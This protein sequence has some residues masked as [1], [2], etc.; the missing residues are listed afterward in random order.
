MGRNATLHFYPRSVLAFGY[1]PYLQMCVCVNSFLCHNS[2][3]VQARILQTFTQYIGWK[4]KVSCCY[5]TVQ[6]KTIF[7]TVLYWFRHY[8]NQRHLIT[9]NRWI[10]ECLLWE[11]SR[12]LTA[13]KRQCAVFENVMSLPWCSL[14]VVLRICRSP[15]F[16]HY[17]SSSTPWNCCPYNGF[18]HSRRGRV[19]GS[20]AVEVAGVDVGLAEEVNWEIFSFRECQGLCNNNYSQNSL[21]RVSLLSS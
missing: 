5:N 17:S 8:T 21:Y 2:S 11:F 9:P 19:V 3:L 13:L 10:M 1:C 7:H 14:A 4:I 12:K 20:G 18:C 6:Y 15:I 16:F